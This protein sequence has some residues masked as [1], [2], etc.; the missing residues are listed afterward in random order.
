MRAKSALL[1]LMVSLSVLFAVNAYSMPILTGVSSDGG[2]TWAQTDLEG[3]SAKAVISTSGSTLE[4]LLSNEAAATTVP[5]TV[6]TGLFFDI[7]GITLSTPH[8]TVAPGSSA[9]SLVSAYHIDGDL[10]KDLLHGTNLDGEY[11]YLH[12]INGINGGLG[13]YGIAATGFDPESG[14]PAGWDGFGVGSIIDGSMNYKP[15]VGLA[16]SEWG[17][18]N[19]DLSGLNTSA[20]D[21]YVNNA[22]VISFDFTGEFNSANITQLNFLYGTSY[23]GTSVPEPAAVLLFG[24]GLIGLASISRKKT[25]K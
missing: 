25:K 10:S 11:G 24:T 19:G 23:E 4:I 14:A 7:D 15:P 9:V 21:S 1:P 5:N 3:R 13:D 18:V 17:L 2:V 6:L 16:V 8:V 20:V 12:P 22:V